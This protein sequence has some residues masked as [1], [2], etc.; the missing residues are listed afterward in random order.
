[1]M[2]GRKTIEIDYDKVEQ[3]AAQGLTERQIAESMGISRDAAFEAAIKAGA[4]RGLEAVTNALWEN[5]T[6]KGNVA[7]A[8]FYLKNRGG[9]TDKAQVEA[10]HSGEV[11]VEHDVAAALEALKRAGI[12]PASL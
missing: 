1:M 10:Q 9:W 2:A 6:Q 3:L 8:I 11:L 12:D 7:A 4:S 5:A